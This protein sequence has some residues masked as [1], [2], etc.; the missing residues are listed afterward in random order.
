[1][2]I[3]STT[4]GAS[5]AAKDEDFL[6]C[7]CFVVQC[8]IFE[9]AGVRSEYLFCTSPKGLNFCKN[10]KKKKNLLCAAEHGHIHGRVPSTV[11]WLDPHSGC[12]VLLKSCC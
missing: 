11:M 3:A 5:R 12:F 8:L 9:R 2:G 4:G 1:M 6:I 10:S 7:Y